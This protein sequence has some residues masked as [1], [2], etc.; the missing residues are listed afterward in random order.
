L[1]LGVDGNFF[2]GCNDELGMEQVNDAELLRRSVTQSPVFAVVYRR[3]AKKVARYIARRVGN[4]TAEDLTAEVFVRALRGRDSYRSE[5][6][7]AFP[8]LLGIAN[9]VIAGHRRAERQRLVMIERLA[10]ITPVLIVDHQGDAALAPE[11][12]RE[13]RRLSDPIRDT[14]LLV[15]WGELSYEEAATAL[16]VPVGT[17][18]SRIARARRRLADVAQPHPSNGRPDD[19]VVKGE[20]HA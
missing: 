3:H 8:W 20:A 6:P 7:T 13:L 10:Q 5:H 1:E 18:R 12:A 14:F 2:A 11:L 4:A 9:H 17:V 15:V 19:V 16:Q